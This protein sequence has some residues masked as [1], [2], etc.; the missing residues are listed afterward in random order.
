MAAFPSVWELLLPN[1]NIWTIIG[2]VLIVLG[3]LIIKGT[4][5]LNFVGIDISK[6]GGLAI[7]LGLFLIWGISIIQDFLSSSGGQ[8]IF[9]GSVIILVL[10]VILF[11]DPKKNKGGR[12]R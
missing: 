5:A 3:F 1:F 12:K 8:L 11:Y 4:F 6:Y 2:I 7:I 10:G 9:W